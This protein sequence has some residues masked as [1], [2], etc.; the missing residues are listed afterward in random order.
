MT[1]RIEPSTEDGRFL[2]ISSKTRRYSFKMGKEMARRKRR[3]CQASRISN[4]AP[5]QKTPETMALVQI[6]HS[7][8]ILMRRLLTNASGRESQDYRPEWSCARSREE[9]TPPAG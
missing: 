1:S 6:A 8:K 5:F 3:F 9:P 2:V 4:G 7:G